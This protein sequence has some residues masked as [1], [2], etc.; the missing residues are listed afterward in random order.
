MRNTLLRFIVTTTVLI[1]CGQKHKSTPV[2]E[3]KDTETSN[4]ADPTEI[5]K[6]VTIS[7]NKYIDTKY[8]YAD[9]DGK[10]IIIENSLPKGGLKYAAPNGEEYVYAIFWT[11]ITNETDNPF[12]LTM[13]FPENSYEL[14]SSPGRFFKLFIPSD[15]MKLDK[16]PLFNYGLDLEN[17]LGDNFHMQA[18]LKRSI[19]PKSSSGFYIITLFNKWVNGTVRTGLSIKEQNI[20][21][22]INDRA[23]HCGSINLKQL[24]G[25]E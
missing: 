24:K 5:Q 22:R 21:Y 11:R 12:E 25:K 17:Y 14:P 20:F 18:E 16:E 23:I 1:S 4:T 8:V 19:N 7:E 3:P 2:L 13:D 6:S 10:Q 9:S 15:T